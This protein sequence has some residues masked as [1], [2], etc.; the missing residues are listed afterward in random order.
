MI[1][2]FGSASPNVLKISIA[3][4]ELGLPFAWRHVNIWSGEQFSPEISRLNPLCKVPILVEATSKGEN[5]IFESGAILLHLADG[6]GNK[7]MPA[8]NA[9][10]REA[11]KWLFVQC[12]NIGP[13]FGQLTHFSKFAPATAD[14]A[15][16]R[17]QGQVR[18]LYEVL[19]RRLEDNEYLAGRFFSVADIATFPWIRLHASH[20]ETLS[21]AVARWF[22]TISARPA[23]ARMVDWQVT[24]ILPVDQKMR[25]AASSAELDNLFPGR[26][27]A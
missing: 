12:A 7:I 19:E 25:A 8:D 15:L 27:T 26:R 21:P 6:G 23:V 14:Y 9:G 2:L 11:I 22:E 13:M 4:E 3:L 16:R 20:V 17:Y 10:R 18:R 1:T 24:T 5:V